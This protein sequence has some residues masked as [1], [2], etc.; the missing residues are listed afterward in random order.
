[1][2]SDGNEIEFIKT[3]NFR[4]CRFHWH[5]LRTHF[6]RSTK[7][8]NL[9]GT[10]NIRSKDGLPPEPQ[11]VSIYC[12]EINKVLNRLPSMDDKQKHIFTK[13]MNDCT[14]NLLLR[15]SEFDFLK[16]EN[17]RM[18]FWI[19]CYLRRTCINNNIMSKLNNKPILGASNDQDDII[20][21][22]LYLDSGLNPEPQTK[23]Q[24][25]SLI[26]EFFDRLPISHVYSLAYKIALLEHFQMEWNKVL[27]IEPF[28]WIDKSNSEWAWHYLSS[29][30][31][32]AIPTFFI[33]IPTDKLQMREA[34]I[35]A[36]D[37]WNAEDNAKELFIIK[38]KRA[39]SQKKHRDSMIGQ[40][41]YSIVMSDGIKAKL[42]FLSQEN[43]Y[44][45]NKIVEKLI[46]QE[47][48]KCQISM[49]LNDG[50]NKQKLK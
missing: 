34:T 10:G 15:D 21:K 45:K 41:A 30:K 37:A 13:I 28:S 32:P 18:C 22:G 4:R 7:A 31:R 35:A 14:D 43:N 42:D 44:T 16:K 38:M 19:W 23:K 33:P 5:Y 49:K 1:M 3:R 26:I 17:S 40:K 29:C 50:Q 47:Y 6:Q 25:Y 8:F 27:K 24:R 48:N 46:T 20:A 39:W 12:L 36:F 2:I 11:S 9:S